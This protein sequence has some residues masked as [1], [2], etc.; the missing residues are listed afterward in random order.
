MKN[1]N[2]KIVLFVTALLLMAG[3]LK[4]QVYIMDEEFEGAMRNGY[5]D[6]GLTVPYEGGDTDQEYVPVGEGLLALSLLGGAYLLTKRKK[7]K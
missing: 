7:N 1:M 3:S 4:A 6:F 2:R 5:E